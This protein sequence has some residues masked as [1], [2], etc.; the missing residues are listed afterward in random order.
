[1]AQHEDFMARAIEISRAAVSDGDAGPFAAVVVKD[2]VVIGEGVNRV[3]ATHDPTSHGE[4][5][6]IRDACRKLKTWDLSGCDL[7][8][9]CEPC[10]MC[11]ATMFWARIDRVFYAAHLSDCEDIGFDLAPLTALV[12]NPPE[13]RATPYIPMMREDARAV[14]IEWARSPG[15]DRF[16]G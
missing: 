6:A 7:Y 10:E 5:E 9:T 11:V 3:V 13:T 4:V 8:T 16:Q 2:G 12:R 14:L 1:M 15:F